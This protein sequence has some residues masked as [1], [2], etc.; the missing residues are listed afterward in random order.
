MTPDDQAVFD[1]T[2]V[3]LGVLLLIPYRHLENRVM[4]AVNAAGY[5]ITLPQARV[6]QRI[7]DEGSRLT[8]LAEAA[9]VTK[10]TAGYLVD[11][12]EQDGY[13]RRVPD[14]RDHRAKLITI[15]RRGQQCIAVAVPVQRQVEKEWAEHLGERASRHLL[16]ALIRLQEITDPYA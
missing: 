2:P 11:Q 8:Q 4:D 7:A 15:T 16:D 1:N 13:V 3:S 14:P 9:Q 12:L 6:F 5:G 10:Q